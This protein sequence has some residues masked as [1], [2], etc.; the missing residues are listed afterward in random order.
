MANPVQRLRYFDGEYLRSYDFT[1]EQSYHIAMRRL[2]NRKLHLHGIIYGLEIV[3]DQ[4][5]IPGGDSFYSIAAGMA[6]DDM[7]REIVVIAP[8]SLTN[9]LTGPNLVAGNA[10]DVWICYDETQTALPAAGYLDCN[11]AS[12]YTRWQEGFMVQLIPLIGPSVVTKCDGV[13]LGTVM[14]GVSASGF[15]LAIAS[16]DLKKRHFVGIRAQRIV[17]P[18]E[19]ADTF[20]ITKQNVDPA[21]RIPL[22]GY[23][24]IEPSALERGNLI[25]EKNVVIGDDF[26]LDNTKYKNLPSDFTKIP[27]GN[28]KITQD[29][30]LNGDFYGFLNGDWLK[31]KDYIQTLMP[32]IVVDTASQAIS[33]EVPANESGTFTVTVTSPILT[34]TPPQ[35]SLALSKITWQSQNSLETNWGPSGSP[36]SVGVTLGGISKS[37]A[38]PKQYDLT[39]G[40]TAAPVLNFSGQNNLPITAL[41]VSYIV[42]FMP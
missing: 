20:D 8:Y 22:P 15:G 10:Y 13:R 5:S 26:P 33:P 38:N 40:W 12:Q 9:V 21:K 34:N 7:G 36:I 3:K 23:L 28:V 27:R 30:F 14:L 16:V 42:I 29:L 6:I 41:T 37:A 32:N 39:I 4:D 35:V 2:M 18:D 31:L 1:D 19:E 25:V 11:A 17:A 24:D